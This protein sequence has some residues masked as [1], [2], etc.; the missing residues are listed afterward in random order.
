MQTYCNYIRSHQGI[1][2]LTPVN[3][4]GIQIDLPDNRWIKMIELA[5]GK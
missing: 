1:G 2:G 3:M 4:A 5:R